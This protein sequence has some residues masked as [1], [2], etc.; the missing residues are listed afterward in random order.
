MPG[1]RRVFGAAFPFIAS[2]VD[3]GFGQRCFGPFVRSATS[4]DGLVLID[5]LNALHARW[6]PLH[7]V[8]G[9]S[10][11]WV[12]CQPTEVYDISTI[13]PCRYF[14]KWPYCL[15]RKLDWVFDVANLVDALISSSA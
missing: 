1:V 13:I 2:G 5:L 11:S 10:T 6:S 15:R 14:T 4:V 7:L 8:T 3:K 9:L 12:P